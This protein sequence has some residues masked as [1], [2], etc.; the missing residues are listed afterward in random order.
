M[1]RVFLRLSGEL[2][3]R[4]K[5]DLSHSNGVNDRESA[6]DFRFYG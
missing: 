3:F 6:K 2:G 5:S 1:D 4:C